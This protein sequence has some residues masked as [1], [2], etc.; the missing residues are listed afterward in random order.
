[1]T[2]KIPTYN[3]CNLSNEFND[4]QDFLVLDLQ[5]YIKEQPD[6]K[7]SSHRHSFF[8]I[9]FITG[10][11]GE[12]FIDFETH[13]IIKG[14]I[15][16]LAPGQVHKWIFNSSTQGFVINF[17]ENFFSSFLARRN[18]LEEFPFFMG[19]G[20]YS[21]IT[22]NEQFERVRDIFE[23]TLNEYQNDQEYSLD[24]I[25]VYLLELFILCNRILNVENQ[26]F[27]E[28][29]HQFL[30]LRNFEKLIEEHYKV[31]KLPKEYSELL[32]VTPNHLNALCKKFKGFSS[33]ELIRNRILLETKRLLVN[34]D[35]SVTEISYHLNFNDNSYFSRFFKKYTGCTPDE[36]R[37]SRY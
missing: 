5:N 20:N 7:A 6:L 35:M 37:S 25:R 28:N 29:K 1:M 26:F 24:M 14:D 9:L 11:N 22:L 33:G 15:Y 3:I 17:N 13:Q 10:G 23:K 30:L 36:F 4:L 19:N 8:Q 18:Y 31:K 16:Y 32:F 34:S 27:I 2:K 21:K 12:H